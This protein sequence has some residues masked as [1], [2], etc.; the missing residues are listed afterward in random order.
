M[1]K[2]L[3]WKALRRHQKIGNKSFS[4][5]GGARIVQMVVVGGLVGHR[6][7]VLLSVGEQSQEGQ[8]RPLL[9]FCACAQLPATQNDSLGDRPTD[10]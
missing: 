1:I 7:Q 5:E 8:P 10:K 4:P 6:Q 2:I 3:V 9:V